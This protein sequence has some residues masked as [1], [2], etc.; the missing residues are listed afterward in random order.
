MKQILCISAMMMVGIVAAGAFPRTAEGATWYVTP[1][2]TSCSPSTP[3][4]G[5]VADPYT[6]LYYAATQSA[7]SCGDTLVLRGGS[8]R[9]RVNRRANGG[10]AFVDGTT[11]QRNANCDDDNV[12]DG[13]SAGYDLSRTVLPLF[14]QCSA[15]NELF[16][17]NYPGED[18]VLDGT[19]TDWD[20]GDLWTRCE[21]SSQCG[22]IT[23]LRLKD[24]S[25]TYYTTF[26]AN[27]NDWLQFWVN[28]TVSDSGKRIGWWANTSNLI[29]S[30]IGADH[31]SFDE[32][33]LAGR[34]RFFS[35]NRGSV[36]VMRLASGI[37]NGNYDPDGHRIKVTDRGFS[38]VGSVI[39]MF[40]GSYITVRKNPAGGSF[41][42]KFGTPIIRGSGR[43]HHITFDGLE[44]SGCGDREYGNCLRTSEAD[45]ITFKNGAA[46][47]ATA[48]VIAFYG[49]GPGCNSGQGCAMQIT[50]NRVENSIISGGGRGFWDGGATGTSLGDGIVL[51]N[52]HNCAAVGNTVSDALARGIRMNISG[53]GVCTQNSDCRSDCSGNPGICSAGLC[54]VASGPRAGQPTNVCCD[55]GSA[56]SG[57][58]FIVDAN[59]IFNVGH[60]QNLSGTGHLYPRPMMG[61]SDGGCIWNVPKDGI[62][63]ATNG[64]ISNNICRGAYSPSI[65]EAVPGIKINWSPP[66]GT[67]ISIVNNTISAVNGPCVS[68]V[69]S[70]QPIVVRNN[71]FNKCALS[72][73]TACGS[74][75]CSLWGQPGVSH[76]HSNN[77]FWPNNP[78]DVVVRMNGLDYTLANVSTFEPTAVKLAPVFVSS[79]NL[80]LA[81]GAPQID[82]GTDLSSIGF[83]TDIDRLSRSLPWD[84]GA[85]EF[86]GSVPPPPPLP[87]SAP[88]GLRL[89]P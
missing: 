48:E 28:P 34:G 20:D 58:N 72:G 11:A 42:A 6:N 56:C 78:A 54:V 33:D 16:I 49:G 12:D 62:H 71:L 53:S 2:S 25:R 13:G 59:T 10:W 39:S 80:R 88:T 63:H 82:A 38:S 9:I 15:G 29:G 1:G 31:D 70:S 8:Y 68:V 37:A 35:V 69:E 61:T 4:S 19:P 21:S 74:G 85:H 87:P 41:R 45:Y 26:A 89:A 30:N 55:T 32:A 60:W 57:D 36:V 86:R 51:K 65:A 22:S 66:A 17:Q 83:A 79:T 18:V 44:L 50:G 43:A 46:S 14:K 76:Q 73:P 5:T 24:F 77:S 64:R 27:S 7:V 67:T 23:G 52:C 81:A 75:S 47:E 3:G 84:I 40:G